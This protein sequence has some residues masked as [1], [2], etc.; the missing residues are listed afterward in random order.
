MSENSSKARLQFNDCVQS[1]EFAFIGFDASNPTVAHIKIPLMHVGANA[2]GLYWTPEVL[3]EI[4]PMFSN[5]TFKYDLEGKEGSSHVPDKLYSPHFD[6]GWTSKAYYDKGS[7]TLWVEGDVTHPDVVS[8]LHRATPNGKR[9]LNYASMGVLIDPDDVS[10]SICGKNMT[11]CGHKRNEVYSGKTAYAIPTRVEKA[12]HVALTNAPADTEAVI[13]EAIFQEARNL[14][15]ETMADGPAGVGATDSYTN[16]QSRPNTL[17]QKQ[18]QPQQNV[19]I[20]QYQKDQ[21]GQSMMAANPT[22]QKAKTNDAVG[23][24]AAEDMPLA[25]P[26]A[27][28]VTPGEGDDDVEIVDV[29]KAIIMRLQAIEEKVGAGAP[30]A[31][32]AEAPMGGAPAGVPAAP[33]TEMADI[34]GKYYK[35]MLSE[36]AD[37]SVN[38]GRYNTKKEA[39]AHFQDRSIEQL[40]ALGDAFEGIEVK[41]QRV[42]VASMPEFGTPRETKATKTFADLSASERKNK[43]GEYASWD[44]C[45]RNPNA[46]VE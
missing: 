24:M 14:R 28:P 8:K 23:A 40:E 9:E 36:V 42:E 44:M 33:P 12:L 31:P 27:A 30:A 43:F 15:G 13:A 7:K 34:A 37:K 25:A 38:L 32:G 39:I 2:K 22:D 19:P 21:A 17:T 18:V 20:S 10:C 29:L 26:E 41:K 5:T 11:E 35:K 6:V 46:Q 45:F 4:A 3:T 1:S 16:Q